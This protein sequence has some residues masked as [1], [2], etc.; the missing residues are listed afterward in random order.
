MGQAVGGAPGA[1][2]N[3][4]P[5]DGGVA[6]PAGADQLN[7]PAGNRR[8]QATR[9]YEL[10]RQISY[11]N[12]DPVAINRLS[13]AVVLDNKASADPEVPAQAWTEAEINQIRT[14]V[15]D[16]VGYDA[17]RGDSVTVVNNIF[18]RPAPMAM[19]SIPLMEQAWLHALLRQVLAGVFI[20]LVVFGVL[21][22]VLQ[23]LAKAG[24]ESRQLAVAATHGDFSDLALAEQAMLDDDMR[25]PG[26]A[27]AALAAPT[28]GYERQLNTVRG[29]VAEDPG[30]VA[31]VVKQWVTTDGE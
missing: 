6:A 20:L 7:D 2:A 26:N 5:V 4:P 22:P 8:Q 14:L 19:E 16:A 23:N 30:R 12:H 10:G 25:L 24:T 28:S 15:Q 29:M 18:A 27:E 9:N 11:T 21:R 17:N 1:L 13:V 31:Q 3:Q